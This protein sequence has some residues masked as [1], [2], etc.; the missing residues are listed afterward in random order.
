MIG[1]LYSTFSTHAT[2]ACSGS[3]IEKKLKFLTIICDLTHTDMHF[4][5]LSGLMFQLT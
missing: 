5:S 2:R 4:L 1:D 3:E